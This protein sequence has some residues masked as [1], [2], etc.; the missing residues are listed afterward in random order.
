MNPLDNYYAGSTFSEGNLQIATA[1]SASKTY[2]TSTFGVSKGKW[3]VEILG[4]DNNS[5]IITG[6]AGRSTTATGNVLGYYNDT[7][8]WLG[9][10]GDL[11]TNDGSQSTA[12]SAYG[13]DTVSIALDLDNNFMYT[14]KNGTWDNSGDPTSGASGTGGFAITAAASTTDGMYRFACGDNQTHGSYNIDVQWNFGSPPFSI[15]SGNADGNGYGNFEYAV[16][17]GYYALC[18]KNLAEFG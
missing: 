11:R 6:I 10:G 14:R 9:D 2:N 18:T 7:W 13:T 8:G 3:Y 1:T 15:S 16:P 5:D 4:L 12:V 17:S